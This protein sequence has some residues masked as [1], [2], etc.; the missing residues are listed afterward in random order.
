MSVQEYS[1]KFTQ[2]SKYA[3]TMVVDPRARMNKFVM[4]VSSL[5][6][7]ECRMTML[8]NDMDISRLM[9]YV[10]QIEESKIREIRQECRSPRTD[11]SCHQQP[12]KSF[13]HQHSSIG[14]KDKAPNQNSQ[15][16]GH[17]F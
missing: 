10:Q 8:L 17:Y 1:L 16:G 6:E 14:N 12:K 13:Y 3:P 4:E 15:G 2:L 5:V 7:K 11:D 9:V